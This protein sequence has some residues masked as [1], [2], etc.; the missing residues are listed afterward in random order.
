MSKQAGGRKWFKYSPDFK[1][2]AV[3]RVAGGESPTRV[4]RELGIRRKF[5]YAWKALAKG[6]Q[7][8][9]GPS[10]PKA[11]DDPQQR[12]I[13]QLQARISELERL[14]GRQTAELDFFAAA[15]RSAKETRRQSGARSG[16]E[17]TK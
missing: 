5:L 12:E 16:E 14:T 10:A 17:S 8:A 7:G 15:V 4:A 6:G 3:D 2:A 11:D 13:A 9:P 1:R